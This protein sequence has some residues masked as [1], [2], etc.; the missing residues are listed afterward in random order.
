MGSRKK[1]SDQKRNYS[2]VRHFVCNHKD[3]LR[4]SAGSFS[5]VT[6]M[7]PTPVLI[8]YLTPMNGPLLRI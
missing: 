2:F 1:K 7:G 3:S 5:K 6:K 8:P 4:L